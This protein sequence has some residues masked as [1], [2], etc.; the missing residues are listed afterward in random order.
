MPCGVSPS[1]RWKYSSSERSTL[2][3]ISLLPLS[4]SFRVTLR[5]PP[6]PGSRRFV[7]GCRRGCRAHGSF[8]ARA[9]RS[10]AARPCCRAG[11]RSARRRRAARATVDRRVASR[12]GTSAPPGKRLGVPAEVLARGA[13]A[14]LLAVERVVVGQMR[15]DQRARLGDRRRRQV[16]RRWRGSA[17]SRGR[18]TA[19]PAPRGRSS[20]ASAPVCA[21]TA[22]RAAPACR[23]R[24]WR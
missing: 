9:R 17:R 15:D 22:P 8:A 16:R 10:R 2:R 6:L 13:H 11:R 23:C 18:S 19:G 7:V 20:G 21:S 14:R 12:G 1:R 24:R 3:P 5:G 4:L